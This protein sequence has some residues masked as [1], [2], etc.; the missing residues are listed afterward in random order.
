MLN[1][2]EVGEHAGRECVSERLGYAPD[3]CADVVVSRI[4]HAEAP[5]VHRYTDDYLV[6][7]CTEA[8]P[9]LGCRVLQRQRSMVA[10]EPLKHIA[11][12]RTAQ[13]YCKQYVS[14]W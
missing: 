5:S 6:F 12:V 7:G 14:C 13:H 8:C 1:Y 3:V 2:L 9:Q 11:K 10:Y 4:L